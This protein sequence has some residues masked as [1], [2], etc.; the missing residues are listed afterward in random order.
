[1]GNCSDKQGMFLD[2]CNDEMSLLDILIILAGQKK[3]ILSTVLLFTLAGAIYAFFLTEPKYSSEV[4]MMPLTSFV[5]DKG[6]FSVQMPGNI[7]GGVIMS[8]ATLDAVVDE[9]GLMKTK[10]GESQSRVT[11]RKELEKEITVDVDNNGVITLKVDAPQPEEA[12]KRANFIY[13]RTVAMLE[14]MGITATVDNKEAYLEKTM[15]EKFSKMEKDAANASDTSKIASMLELYTML[16]QYDENQKIK[17]KNPMVIQL[18]SPAS[19]PDEKV[20][21]GRGKIVALSALLGLF[22]AVTLAFVRHSWISAGENAAT[23]EKKAR[24]RALLSFKKI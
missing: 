3:L 14:E 17:N 12:M 11:A 15:R 7:V 13:G 19:L 5:L 10:D 1:M 23:A 2:D 21:Q 4:Q 24:L 6:D 9:F 8:N 22:C 18:I 16:T 20:P